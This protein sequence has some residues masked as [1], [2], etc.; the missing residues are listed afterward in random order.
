MRRPPANWA[1]VCAS[2]SVTH[3]PQVWSFAATGTEMCGSP[4]L[5]SKKYIVTDFNFSDF[6]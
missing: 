3:V 6:L 5:T 2:F 4:R 1:S